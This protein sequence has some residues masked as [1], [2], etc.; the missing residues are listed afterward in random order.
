MV[1]TY[2][3]WDKKTHAHVHVWC[4]HEMC[5]H[6]LQVHVYMYGII[7]YN[8]YVYGIEHVTCSKC[9][10]VL[11]G[12]AKHGESRRSNSCK[13]IC[14]VGICVGVCMYKCGVWDRKGMFV[15]RHVQYVHS[16]QFF[17]RWFSSHSIRIESKLQWIWLQELHATCWVYVKWV[18]NTPLMLY[19]GL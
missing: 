17:L 5:T 11:T 1:W 4:I 19:G 12:E 2:L 10:C 8:M 14:S 3:T 9:V 15:R 18:Y 7:V 16:T 6:L 13:V